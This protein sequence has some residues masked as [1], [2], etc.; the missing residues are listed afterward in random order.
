MSKGSM[1]TGIGESV[2]WIDGISTGM[3]WMGVLYMGRDTVGIV[4][5]GTER[6]A[7]EWEHVGIQMMGKGQEQVDKMV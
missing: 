5:N 1:G 2:K 6:V 3:I 7:K 4:S